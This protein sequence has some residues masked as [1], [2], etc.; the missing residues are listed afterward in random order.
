VFP[1]SRVTDKQSVKEVTGMKLLLSAYSCTPGEGSERGTG[2]NWAQCL[3]ANGYEVIV[4]TRAV[5][6]QRIEGFAG[7][8]P[9]E[10][11]RFI[12]HD[13]SPPWQ[14]IYK[15]PLGNYAYYFLWQYTAAKLASKLHNTERFDRVQHL[16]WGSFR[17]PSFMGRLTIPFIFGPVGGGEDTPK[18]L[19]RGL[20]WRGRLFDAMRRASSALM[21]PCM[22][23]TYR[24]ASEIVA[25][26]EE[27]LRKIPAK[28]RHK[29]SVRQ[30]VGIDPSPVENRSLPL[31]S[32]PRKSS[33]LELVFVGRLFP[34][35]GVHLIL[36]ALALL[37]ASLPSVHLTVIGTG[38]DLPRLQ[39][40]SRRLKVDE[41][42]SWVPWI[43]WEEMIRAYQQFDLFTFPSLHDSGGM[44][45]LEAMTFGL[46]VVCLDL[47][48]PG[49]NVNNSCGRVIATQG[50][51]E[52]HVVR[53]M[54]QFLLEILVNRNMLRG[55]S[56]SARAHAATLTWQAKVDAVYGESLGQQ[57]NQI[58]GVLSAKA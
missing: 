37:E 32:L 9:V 36:K 19:R 27:T 2:W 12:F 56:E 15:L 47:G 57:A 48:G 11:I 14:L 10:L 44:A 55:L 28:Y 45:V 33:R 18:N 17:V 34:W 58:Q 21:S 31:N 51:S 8:H 1:D 43:P 23:F 39:H 29:I 52:D 5:D 6:Q 3:A 7:D 26:T 35:K 4:M 16:T 41:F 20:G 25:T 24:T 53:E 22:G 49:I 54:A 42:V 30:G 38:K 40:L 50:V 13:L 46:P